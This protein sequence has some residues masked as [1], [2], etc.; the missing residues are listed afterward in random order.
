MPTIDSGSIVKLPVPVLDG[1]MSVEEALYTRRSLRS[2][3]SASLSLEEVSQL[4]W[5]AQGISS[6]SGYRTAPS[7]GALYPLELYAIVGNIDNLSPG[8]Y[9]YII[10]KHALMIMLNGDQ[11]NNICRAA[12][13]QIFIAKAPLVMLICTVDE[14]VT[15]KYGRRGI[16]YIY[17]E[18]GH[19]AQN[20]CLQAVAL[21]LGTVVIGAFKD[22][23]IA[24]IV[25]LPG[26][27]HPVY[28]IPT[29][30]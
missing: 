12:L 16:K 3:S 21:G 1:K 28:L 30:R 14:R 29:G 9:K 22:G 5:A 2:F 6:P 11:R 25:N 15:T 27:E 18:V 20:V 26:N 17:M 8:I 24:T 23:D 4:L 19:A 7:A 10:R 13:N